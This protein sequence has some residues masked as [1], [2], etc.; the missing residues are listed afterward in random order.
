MNEQQLVSKARGFIN[1]ARYDTVFFSEIPD[2]VFMIVWNIF[3]K[4]KVLIFNEDSTGFLRK[5]Y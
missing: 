1:A 4:E 3:E 5:N 2:D